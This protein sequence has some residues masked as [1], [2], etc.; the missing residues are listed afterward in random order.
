MNS[1][2]AKQKEEKL[3]QKNEE[4]FHA[5]NL[6]I[7]KE[8]GLYPI[9]FERKENIFIPTRDGGKLLAFTYDCSNVKK[10]VIPQNLGIDVNQG[11]L[12]ADSCLEVIYA[13]VNLLYKAYQ[14]SLDTCMEIT[15]E[16]IALHQQFVKESVNGDESKL[17]TFP[18]QTNE[19]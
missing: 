16:L 15:N 9:K 17:I 18:K 5:R 19:V 8:K 13:T 1:K 14:L 6:S 12:D 10:I 3:I 4:D 11:G 2:K 7:L